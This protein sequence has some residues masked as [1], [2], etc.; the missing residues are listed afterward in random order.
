MALSS[1]INRKL[2]TGNGVTTTFS[3]PYLFQV[4]AD[5]VVLKTEI[6]SGTV[7]T[8]TLNSD[9]TVT[10]AGGTSGNVVF[11]TAPSALFQI[12]IYRDP[13]LTQ[14]VTF[15][16][17]PL[18]A[19]SLNDVADKLTMIAQRLDERVDRAM[20]LSDGDQGSVSA[21]LP[22]AQALKPIR[23]NAAADA[24]ENFTIS[25]GAVVS[26]S[27]AAEGIVELATQAEVDSG[28]SATLAVTPATLAGSALATRVT[29]AEAD[30]DALQANPTASNILINGG[31]A[32]DQRFTNTVTDD[33]YSLDRWYVLSQTGAVST[34]QITSAEN[35]TP[36]AMRLTNSSGGSQRQGVAQIIEN[37]NCSFLRGQ[38]VAFSARVR[39][40]VSATI[41]YA[42]LEWTGT[43][44]SVTSD[45]VLSWTSGTYT[46]GSFFINVTTTVAAVG[47]RAVTA[48][49]WTDL[50]TLTATISSSANNI[51]V[52]IWTESTI[53]LGE[54]LD[55]ARAQLTKGATV[56]TFLNENFQTTLQKC[57]RYYAKSFAYGTSPATNVGA[58]TGEVR[59]PQVVGASTAKKGDHV[60]FPV[61]MR[62]APSVTLYN[63]GAANAE[64]R[65][66][67]AS[68]DCTGTAAAQVTAKS[69]DLE[70][71]SAGGTSA[72]QAIGIHYA[73]D[74]EL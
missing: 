50:T 63:P 11:A 58:G 21:E 27:T 16:D 35:G 4:D 14:E 41:R 65:N 68:A 42:I 67:T 26:A 29:A 71:T 38:T 5:L 66:I 61:H 60:R 33:N 9:Y 34:S 74:A 48:N 13:A 22:V 72:G 40:S 17:G 3:F 12:T 51:V 24:L 59:F 53:A 44:D 46:A 23:W 45:V 6:S 43:A 62:T 73:A 39:P 30:I 69:F 49:T 64:A 19:D 52:F 2:Y 18:P 28:A 25:A 56:P 31:F 15:T 37:R 47:S 10:G 57:L 55:V 70:Y 1:L 32:V 20:V 36:F 8:L 7:T 54:K